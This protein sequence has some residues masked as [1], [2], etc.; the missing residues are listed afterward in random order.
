M[1]TGDVVVSPMADVP[2]IIDLLGAFALDAVDDDERAIVEEHLAVCARCRAEVAEH[3]EVAS[4]LA[5]GGGPAPEGLWPRIADSLAAPPP[6]LRLAPVPPS[7][8]APRRRP[9]RGTRAAPA[10]R[11][12]SPTP[13]RSRARRRPRPA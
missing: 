7:G 3:R 6:E 13:D 12:P 4:L 11:V 10:R 9:C 1:S 5:H 2:E 8:E